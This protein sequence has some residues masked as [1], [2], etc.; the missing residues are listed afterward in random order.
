M[1]KKELFKNFL[2]NNP[3]ITNY[4]HD[5]KDVSIQ[6]LY[7]IYDIYGEDSTAWQPY[8]DYQAKT[9][10]SQNTNQATSIKD[11]MKN[12]D[13][14]NLQEHIKT[15]Q[16]ALGFIEELTTKG[17]TNVNSI[18]KGPTSPRPLDKFFGD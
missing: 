11:L 1:D 2:R 14:N 16:K 6:N 8:L 15:A 18:P 13:I 5:N 7:E 12:I 10:T 3:N 4:L 17:A 9:K